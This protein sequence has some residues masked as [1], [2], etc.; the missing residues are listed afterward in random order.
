M[1][2]SMK[3]TTFQQTIFFSLIGVII[4]GGIGAAIARM[5]QENSITPPNHIPSMPN[6]VI[7]EDFTSCAAAGNPIMESYPR[8]CRHIDGRTFTEV[9]T[10]PPLHEGY[11]PPKTSRTCAPAGCSSQLCVPR[12]EAP[13]IATTCEWTPLYGCYQKSVCE[14][15]EN[16]ECG[17]TE[18]AAFRACVE[19]VA[20]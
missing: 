13:S 17:W 8:Q 15:Q 4:L 3:Y 10:T 19:G 12:E 9:V 7:V 1:S 6:E 14:R 11:A 18:T 2:L 20:Q 16:G 5:G